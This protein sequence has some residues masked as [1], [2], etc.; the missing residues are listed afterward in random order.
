[1]FKKV[2][3]SHGLILTPQHSFNHSKLNIKSDSNRTC[4]RFVHFPAELFI[5]EKQTWIHNKEKGKK[6]ELENYACLICLAY[7]HSTS[8]T[9]KRQKRKKGCNYP[10]GNIVSF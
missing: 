5:T 6:K 2:S 7:F 1:M 4:F 9:S 10:V 8:I 3:C